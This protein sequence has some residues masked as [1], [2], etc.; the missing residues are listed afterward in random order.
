M[1][2]LVFSVPLLAAAGYILTSRHA[3]GRMTASDGTFVWHSRPSSFGWYG[4]FLTGLMPLLILLLS[5]AVTPGEMITQSF[6]AIV[7]FGSG[8]AAMILVRKQVNPDFQAR[9]HVERIG[10]TIL[11]LCALFSILVTASIV[12]SV[13]FEAVR[14]FDKVPMSEFF[15]GL[16]WSPQTAMRAD[17]AGGSG[18]FG[19]IP[20]F[21]GTLLI[22]GVAMLVAVPIGLFSAIYMAEYAKPKTRTIAKPMLELLA[23][24]PTVV[25]GYFA[26]TAVAPFLRDL[27]IAL[28]LDVASES[29]LTAGLVMGVMI[30]PLISSLSDDVITAVPQAMRDASYGLGS[31]KSE[32]IRKVILPAALPGI[33]GAILLAI[34][35]AIGETMIVVMAAGL[36]ANLTINPL[37]SVTTVTAQIVALLTGDQEFDS[38]KTLAAFALGLALFIITLILNVIALII[39]KRYREEY[40]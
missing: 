38:A 26:I 13:L 18:S 9:N 29:A 24:I 17:Q 25:Y 36:A 5:L 21:A 23:G 8:L 11:F 35:R 31:T 20:L 6:L 14:F 40:E 16:Q 4:A 37:E 34:S 3:K 12:F 10:R 1:T 32:A 30:I 27:G 2:S 22:T 33:I 39:V 19:A 28:G 15:L 7:L